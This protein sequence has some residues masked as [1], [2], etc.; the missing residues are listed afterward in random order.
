MKI[1]RRQLRQIIKEELSMLEADSDS[2]RGEKLDPDLLKGAYVSSK[3]DRAAMKD[4]IAKLKMKKKTTDSDG[5]GALDADEL[6][7]I[8]DDLEGEEEA[9]VLPNPYNQPRGA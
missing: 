7:A 1:T 5:D 8:A 4:Y 2:D 6:R 3:E 9:L